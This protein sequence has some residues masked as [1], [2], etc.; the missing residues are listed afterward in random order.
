M[1]SG[2]LNG[3]GQVKRRSCGAAIVDIFN[4]LDTLR[5]VWLAGKTLVQ[6]P[7]GK[8][9]STATGNEMFTVN[10]VERVNE[11]AKVEQLHQHAPNPDTTGWD[12]SASTSLSDGLVVIS[13]QTSCVI[14]LRGMCEGY[15][16]TREKLSAG[17]SAI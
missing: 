3:P 5:G 11:P 16:D 14:S 8:I 2:P 6:L 1:T 9:G 4:I 13:P 7:L 15:T 17:I 10:S 12:S